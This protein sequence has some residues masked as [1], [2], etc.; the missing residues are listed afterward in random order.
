[1]DVTPLYELGAFGHGTSLLVAVAIGVG[2]GWF[3]ER[4]GMG[5]ARK[6]AGQFYLTDLTVFKLMFSAILTA[7][8]GLWWLTELGVVEPALLAVPGTWVAPQLV[9]GVVFG[10]GFVMGGLCPGTSC[11]AA[12]SG[13]LDG[14]ALMGGML[15][16]VAVFAEAYPLI[17]P[18]HASTPRGVVTVP[19]ALGLPP[20][21]VVAVVTVIAL[22]GFVVAEWVEA[23]HVGPSGRE[24][25]RSGTEGAKGSPPPRG[26]EA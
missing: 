7:M 17:A 16:G 19:R 20:A 23:R 18:F 6:L 8:L 10:V 4:G 15:A 21:L 2:F 13:R 3:L 25:G 14:L 11:V 9:G 24:R 12:S 1:V 22:G 5:N 26:L